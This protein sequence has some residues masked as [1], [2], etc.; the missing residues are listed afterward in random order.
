[1][2]DTYNKHNVQLLQAVFD[3][4]LDLVQASMEY[5]RCYETHGG[6]NIHTG[7]AWDVLIRAETAYLDAMT[8]LEAKTR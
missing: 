7:R 1:M 6:G 5:R 4:G 8:K 3:T 2:S